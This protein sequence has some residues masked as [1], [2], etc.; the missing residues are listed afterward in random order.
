MHQPQL[1]TFSI[2]NNSFLSPWQQVSSL[3]DYQSCY[4][5]TIKRHNSN[6]VSSNIFLFVRCSH[7]L[8][9]RPS[10]VFQCFTWIPTY[11]EARLE[12]AHI[13]FETASWSATFKSN[14]R[15]WELNNIS[16]GMAIRVLEEVRPMQLP[17]LMRI[18]I[19]SCKAKNAK[20]LP[21]PTSYCQQSWPCTTLLETY[22]YYTHFLTKHHLTKIWWKSWLH[23]C[24]TLILMWLW[25]LRGG[26]IK[27]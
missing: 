24:V 19:D 6:S 10:H 17:M 15:T 12:H 7:S 26:G 4:N 21:Q 27:S 20:K 14:K 8:I 2:L 16:Y 22:Y 13:K 1:N 9:P 11:L 18:E 5:I 23:L 3:R 25:C